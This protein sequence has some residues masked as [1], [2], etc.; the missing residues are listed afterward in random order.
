M[1]A[2]VR[3]ADGAFYMHNTN[4]PIRQTQRPRQKISPH[5]DADIFFCRRLLSKNIRRWDHAYISGSGESFGGF[6]TPV[7][8]GSLVFS[9]CASVMRITRVF[10]FSLV[11]HNQRLRT[12]IEKTWQTFSNITS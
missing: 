1:L 3:K 12:C 8:L 4:H 6:F 10:S 11:L 5:T 2:P 7:L 9:V